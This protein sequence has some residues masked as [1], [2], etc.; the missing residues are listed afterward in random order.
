MQNIYLNQYNSILSISNGGDNNS[1]I[2]INNG[3]TKT[4][5]THKRCSTVSMKIIIQTFTSILD[6][7]GNIYTGSENFNYYINNNP[8]F[9]YN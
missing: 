9:F 2:I 6:K 5:L 1:L 8:D 3:H 7:E 4:T